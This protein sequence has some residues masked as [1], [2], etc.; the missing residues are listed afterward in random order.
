VATE[1][2]SSS[3]R[4]LAAAGDRTCP[5]AALY[6]IPALPN[7]KDAAT[8]ELVRATYIDTVKRLAPAGA[9]S[10]VLPW[11]TEPNT[12]KGGIL[13]HTIVLFSGSCE[14]GKA[15]ARDL[16]V[17]LLG[18]VR[19][20]FYVPAP[21]ARSLFGNVYMV[22]VGFPYLADGYGRELSA[23]AAPAGTNLAAQFSITWWDV[24]PSKIGDLQAAAFKAALLKQLPAGAGVY[25]TTMI[26]Q[27]VSYRYGNHWR[28]C[29][30]PVSP[31]IAKSAG[32]SFKGGSVWPPGQPADVSS[33]RLVF[34]TNI[35]GTV[36][37]T[38]AGK[39]TL[40]QFLDGLRR[41]TAAVF[42]PAAFGRMVLNGGSGLRLVND[43][44][45]PCS[46][47]AVPA[48][49][50]TAAQGFGPYA[51]S[52]AAAGAANVT[53][54]KWRFT[55]TPAGGPAISQEVDSPLVWWYNLA[56]DTSYT[57][58]VVGV[59]SSG[60]EAAS[61]NSLVIR[62]G[63]LGAPTV[64]AASPTGPTTALV[65][66]SPPTSG[67]AVTRYTVSVCLKATPSKC[68]A[69]NGTSTQVLVAGLA[70]GAQY[71]VTATAVVGGSLVPAS[72]SLP[73]AMPAAGAPILLT[74]TATS[75]VTGAATAAAPNGAI[76]SQYTFT[77]KPLNGGAS[78]TSTVPN[79]LNGRFTGLKA[80]TQYDVTVV[81][82][83]N[84]GASP[85]SNV[86]PF[87]TPAAS[88][89]LN[90]GAARSATVIVISIAPPALAPVNGGTWAA[91]D[92][93]VC[94][95]SG[96]QSVCVAQRVSASGRRR[97][98]ALA[99]A[100]FTGRVPDT[101]YNFVSVAISSL[102]ERSAQSVTGQVATP[103]NIAPPT[104][105]VSNVTP[106][107]ALATVTPPPTNRPWSSYLLT[108][109]VKDT[110]DCITTTCVAVSSPNSP[111]NCS[112]TALAMGTAYTLTASARRADGTQSSSS[113]PVQFTT[114]TYPR[115]TL[116][117]RDV[118][119]VS[120]VA[121]VTPPTLGRPWRSYSLVV[122]VKGT[123]S[124]NT[125]A[126][127]AAADP[128]SPTNCR[129]TKLSMGV[130]YTVTATARQ[131]DGT[132]SPPSKAVQFTTTTYTEPTVVVG[133][134]T[135]TS[136]VATVTPPVKGRP[137]STYI[138]ALCFKGTANCNTTSC[139]AVA[140]ANKPT[141]CSLTNLSMATAYTL[142]VAA[143]RSDGD[144]SPDSQPV[145]FT[146]L[147]YP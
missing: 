127:A 77:A 46:C 52:A 88:A 18:D 28:A 22:T 109:C 58:R 61:S 114:T 30:A 35:H 93:T 17:K 76:F 16:H 131:S 5:R 27:G 87:V 102:G 81:G 70:A 116:A 140:S 146:T 71:T 101:V 144:L 96:P 122:C 34:N 79:P 1:L 25:F 141:N 44:S 98:L 45:F 67:A 19:P 21:R 90:S 55:A 32:S 78:A 112:L 106:T 42:P 10:D 12:L 53:W 111:T 120:A 63:R 13:V 26:T 2:G 97:L 73:L 125:T 11:S 135:P 48:P 145:Q 86:L 95:V 43:P 3:L 33:G 113:L 9:I 38:A 4:R 136:A 104:V 31:T 15:A 29:A 59:S 126:C 6:I 130:T 110:L 115:P 137:W 117:V 121:I 24:P 139:A 80:A 133:S 83:R 147:V 51:A 72:N 119:S 60:Q 8:F 100:T 7:V 118:T 123:Q 142:T 143:R 65:R 94:P 54:A 99:T 40:A 66:L 132:Q 49:V 103:A 47:E 41:N 89:P 62:T 138:L 82:R 37:N 129:L 36:F 128:D 84:G 14:V 92:V 20:L 39:A 50:L 75:A 57:I 69:A 105:A 23:P 124:C 64:A 56:P 91:Y 85:A 134:I 107:S 68:V 108:V 74:A